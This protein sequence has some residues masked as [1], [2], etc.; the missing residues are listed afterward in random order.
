MLSLFGSFK[1]L[2]R[3]Q[4]GKVEAALKYQVV[5]ELIQNTDQ[6]VDCQD[7]D[8]FTGNESKLS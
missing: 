1:R 4:T 8:V 5:S 6:R 2:T 3:N 7:P